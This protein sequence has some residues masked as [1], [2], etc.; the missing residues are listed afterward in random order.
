MYRFKFE[1]KAKEIGLK[2]VSFI[3]SVVF[4]FFC[5]QFHVFS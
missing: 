2:V 1:E 4:S 3:I 5:V